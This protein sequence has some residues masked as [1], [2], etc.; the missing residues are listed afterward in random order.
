MFC[1][2]CN[3][4]LLLEWWEDMSGQRL[5]YVICVVCYTGFGVLVTGVLLS[6]LW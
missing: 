6:Y 2:T 1:G 3:M 4:G 5:F